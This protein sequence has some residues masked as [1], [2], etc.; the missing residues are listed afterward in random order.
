M[1]QHD[2]KMIYAYFTKKELEGLD[3]LQ[4]GIS[5]DPD[6]GLREY[7]A[8]DQI[9]KIPAIRELFQ[10]TMI[11]LGQD[12]KLTP[13]LETVYKTA[14]KNAPAFREEAAGREPA[15]DAVEQLGQGKDKKL[16]YIPVS[17]AEFFI[18]LNEGKYDLNPKDDL[19]QFGGW[20]PFRA[21]TNFVNKI[22]HA[23]TGKKNFGTEAI[24]V[25]GTVGGYM[26]GGPM[27]AGLGNAAAS[28]ATGKSPQD[29]LMG[30]LKNTALT[31][32]LGQ[33]AQALGYASGAPGW[34]GLT[35]PMTWGAM[36]APA[37]ATAA[38]APALAGAS[39]P[40]AAAASTPGLLES[41]KNL[42]SSP[43]GIAAAMAGLAYMGSNQ[44]QKEQEKQASHA[45]DD[46]ENIREKYG[47]NDSLQ[48][49]KRKKKWIMNPDFHQTEEEKDR[50]IIRMPLMKKIYEDDPD[51]ENYKTGGHVKL[52][53]PHKSRFVQ[54]AGK[55]QDDKIK[56]K[57][58]ANCYILDATTVANAGDGSSRQ[59][60]KVIAELEKTVQQKFIKSMPKHKIARI[61]PEIIRKQPKLP[62][63]LSDG[64]YEINP[65]AV[66]IIGKGSN[67]EGAKLLKDMV[68]RLRRIKNSNG[69]RLPPKAPPLLNLLRG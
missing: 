68:K 48:K 49:P 24:R 32:G 53:I 43:G 33:G 5:L 11:D 29:A 36:G 26:L 13:E 52:K 37:A 31:Y 10:N 64:E 1:A 35:T 65:S 2:P 19:L 22:G 62:V 7:S 20:N 38:G 9:I 63:Y 21:A 30:G 42:L 28:W 41:A 39:T 56:T 25:A 34:A 3:N 14:R 18:E 17:L 23:F 12:G 16:A 66:S 27:G 54:G 44:H 69:N 6:T 67:V 59:G 60:A 4:G 45:A 58:P 61:V 46:I 40:T 47:F 57:V 15:I 8:I 55:G 51:Y 50:G